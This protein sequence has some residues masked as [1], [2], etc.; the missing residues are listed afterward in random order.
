MKDKFKKD[1]DFVNPST[2]C[3]REYALD[4][5]IQQLVEVKKE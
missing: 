3:E 2:D 4:Q 5:I 1:K